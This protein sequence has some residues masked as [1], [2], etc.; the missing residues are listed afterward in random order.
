M[1]ITIGGKYGS[2]GKRVAEKAAELLGYKLCDDDIISE[3]VKNSNVDLA[4]ETFRLFDESQ[5]D[6]P[7]T[8]LTKLSA[9]QK[10][11][12][13]GMVS[14]LS[15]DVLPLDRR[16]AKAQ[17]EVCNRFADEGNC[18]LMGR[19]A[20]HYLTGREDCVRVFVV[21]E[22]DNRVQRIMKHFDIDEKS[23]KKAIRKTDKR[24]EDYY[25]FFTGKRWGDLANY[26]LIIHCDF[27]GEDGTAAMLKSIVELKEGAKK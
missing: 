1:I 13:L 14:T 25:S 18:I 3:A 7:L 16:M 21:D 15:L 11:N 26:D 2:G 6:A 9:I 17:R 8:E 10:S 19:C 20:D 23:A 5:G 24:R 27:L 4:E 22:L 12:Y